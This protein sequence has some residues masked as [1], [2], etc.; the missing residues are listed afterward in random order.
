MYIL[1]ILSDFALLQIQLIR[2]DSS[3]LII[4]LFCSFQVERLAITFHPGEESH[5]QE[6]STKSFNDN[7]F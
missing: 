6:D 2:S 3:K 1:L 4:L 5:Q 7:F